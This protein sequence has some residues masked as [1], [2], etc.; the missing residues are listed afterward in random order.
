[1]E[2][3]INAMDMVASTKLIRAREALDGI[4]PIYFDLKRIVTELGKQREN[5]DHKFFKDQQAK[6]TLYIILTSDRGLSGSYNSAILKKV[7]AHM[8]QG[9]NEKLIIVG[10]KGIEFFKNK[11]KDII[12]EVYDIE[13]KN[14]FY[15][16]ESMA[17]YIHEAFLSD[18]DDIEEVYIA[19]TH[20]KNV[21]N[22]EPRVEKLL[23]VDMN[24]DEDAYESDV[25]YEPTAA[26]FIDH[27]IPLYLH[28]SLFRA[29]SEAHTSEQ[30]AR[31]VN[32]DAAGKNAS[33]LLEDLNRE[34]NRKRQ[35]E[36]TQEL[37][38]IVGSAESMKKGGTDDH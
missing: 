24:V 1:M 28:M 3:I 26:V 11:D 9:K 31:M 36:I 34:Y 22:L 6:N 19:Y 38:E 17:N 18:E 16:A 15:G 7:F 10:T 27:V 21:L 25:K 14:V 2:Q 5:A 12:R 20:F 29:F 35:A 32:M 30:A 4:R 13:D 37:S 8:E 23:P 33:D